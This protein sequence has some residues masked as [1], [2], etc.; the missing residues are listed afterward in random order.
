VAAPQPT[1]F[2]E[3]MPDKRPTRDAPGRAPWV[4]AGV[5]AAVAAAL[6]VLLL[7]V[8]RPAADKHRETAGENAF[9]A[10]EGAA[11]TAARV[12][13]VNLLTYSRKSFDADFAR[14]LAGTTGQL[15]SDLAKDKDT[16]LKSLTDNKFDIK[17]EITD[18][19]LEG[20]DGA[21]GVQ[22]LL[23]ANGF[24]VDDTGTSSVAVP[25][26]VQLTMV[27]VGGKWLAT[28]LQGVD[29]A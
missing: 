3:I 7:V 8:V 16:T 15:K 18:V 12:E 2:E 29:L 26:R 19:A 23:V 1:R 22:V 11:M 17:A 9:S 25:K 5:L 21:K 4:T 27:E 20:S 14:A 13:A 10:S 24:R 28:D 6:L